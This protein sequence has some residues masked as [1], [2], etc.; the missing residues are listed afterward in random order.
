MERM[1]KIRS[2]QWGLASDPAVAPIV[3]NEERHGIGFG[4]EI[5]TFWDDVSSGLSMS[6][7]RPAL[8]I[9]EPAFAPGAACAGE[10]TPPEPF[11]VYDHDGRNLEELARD[12][13]QPS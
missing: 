12:E 2:G 1:G 5:A 4:S 9:S 11:T 8:R 3:D 13:R 10:G 6:C 7:G